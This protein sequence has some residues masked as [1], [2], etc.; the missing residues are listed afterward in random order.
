MLFNQEADRTLFHS[1]L[2]LLKP[3]TVP[4]HYLNIERQCFGNNYTSNMIMSVIMNT[5]KWVFNLLL[6][7]MDFSCRSLFD[8]RKQGCVENSKVLICTFILVKFLESYCCIYGNDKQNIQTADHMFVLLSDRQLHKHADTLKAIWCFGIDVFY[9]TMCETRINW[10]HVR[11]SCGQQIGQVG[12]I[13]VLSA[14]LS[15]QTTH[16]G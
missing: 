8:F 3:Q 9:F 7:S 5:L 13:Q 10:Q 14:V 2:S 6:Y 15:T 16:K 12:F 11:R 1:L 4:A